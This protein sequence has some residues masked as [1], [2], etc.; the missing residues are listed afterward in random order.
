MTP[1]GLQLLQPGFKI[2]WRSYFM[3]VMIV[4]MSSTIA[5]D[6]LFLWRGDAYKTI[7]AL[8]LFG[9]LVPVRHLCSFFDFVLNWISFQNA[10]YYLV[11]IGPIGRLFQAL[12]WFGGDVV[13]KEKGEGKLAEVLDKRANNLLQMTMIICVLLA[14]GCLAF[15]ITPL[16][17][18][19][20]LGERPLFI[21]LAF[22]FLD[23]ETF[24]GY[25]AN[26]GYHC[27]LFMTAIPCNF[28]IQI[29]ISIIPNNLLAAVDLV[30]LSM[31]DLSQS[32]QS[33]VENTHR[34]RNILV[35]IQD[36]DR[37]DIFKDDYT[38]SAPSKI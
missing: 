8:S 9:I 29:A 32:N 34:L 26:L 36:I 37:W 3:G 24:S 15:V 14:V 31:E 23:T 35:Q 18:Y 28:G 21:P 2:V 10:L 38:F 7:Q 1:F 25:Y 20:F 4:I 19:L 16:Y 13:F 22:F 17:S 6:V 33:D 30:I 5:Y 12:V 27:V 11:A